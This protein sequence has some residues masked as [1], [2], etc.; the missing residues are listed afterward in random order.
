M[1]VNM[2]IEK[3]RQW[4]GGYAMKIFIE[5]FTGRENTY[6]ETFVFTDEDLQITEMGSQH[7]LKEIIQ[8]LITIERLGI[9]TGVFQIWDED[10]F[11]FDVERGFL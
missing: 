2:E 1:I 4:S 8:Q 5:L 6:R 10:V 7:H 3:V 9:I 11:H